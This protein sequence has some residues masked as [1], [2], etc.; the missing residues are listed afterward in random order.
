MWVKTHRREINAE[1]HEVYS[2]GAPVSRARL[3]AQK[4]MLF[5]R[6]AWKRFKLLTWLGFAPS[7]RRV[8]VC[9]VCHIFDK[10]VTPGI[11]KWYK[12]AFLALD[13]MLKGFHD[14]HEPQLEGLPRSHSLTYLND[15]IARI[16]DRKD[17][18]SHAELKDPAHDIQTNLENYVDH[19]EGHKFHWWLWRTLMEQFMEDVETPKAG[20]SYGVFD[21]EEMFGI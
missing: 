12:Q 2:A 13:P 1:V 10:E 15:L 3:G 5:K 19:L 20:Y 7:K 9:Q 16:N 14:T 8:D 17:V 21:F 4:R 11:E 18:P 6:L